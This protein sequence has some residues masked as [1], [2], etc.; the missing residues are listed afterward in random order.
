MRSA[1]A[2]CELEGPRITGPRTSL[3]MLGGLMVW[4]VFMGEV[5]HVLGNWGMEILNRM[6]DFF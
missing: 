5:K 2:L 3:K 6:L 4:G 1:A